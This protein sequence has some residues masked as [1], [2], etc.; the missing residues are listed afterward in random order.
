[1]ESLHAH[2][3]AETAAQNNLSLH[4]SRETTLHFPC[5]DKMIGTR[6]A[7]IHWLQSQTEGLECTGKHR[8][9]FSYTPP[10]LICP[11]W[12]IVNQSTFLEKK[13]PQRYLDSINVVHV[14]RLCKSVTV[15]HLGLVTITIPTRSQFFYCN[16]LTGYLQLSTES[17]KARVKIKDTEQKGVF[18]F[19]HIQFPI[20][21]YQVSLFSMC[22]FQTM[23]QMGIPMCT[24]FWHTN[25]RRRLFKFSISY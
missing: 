5:G 22:L 13:N 12:H 7:L 23:S 19:L 1:M 2:D 11:H 18:P 14:S 24:Y 15:L 9:W 3:T 16:R 8:K 21:R 20:C 4:F 25:I 10:F 6:T 17:P